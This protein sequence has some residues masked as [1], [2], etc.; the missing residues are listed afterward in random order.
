M[1]RTLAVL[2]LIS[3]T[4]NIHAQQQDGKAAARAIFASAAQSHRAVVDAEW[5]IHAELEAEEEF[6]IPEGQLGEG[7]IRR[8]WRVES[9]AD[10]GAG[11]ALSGVT[12]Y[13]EQ[14]DGV[15]LIDKPRVSWTIRECKNCID[16]SARQSIHP[17]IENASIFSMN[18]DD[19]SKSDDPIESMDKLDGGTISAGLL[20]DG[21][22]HLP[23]DFP[24]TVTTK[25][26]EN[27]AV[28]RIKFKQLN[29]L[30]IYR[31]EG[32]ADAW[33]FVSHSTI[34]DPPD[35]ANSWTTRIEWT[36]IPSSDGKAV[37][38]PT[39]WESAGRVLG[40]DHKKS[41]R[42]LNAAIDLESQPKTYYQKLFEEKQA[43][44]K[45]LSEEEY[46]LIESELRKERAL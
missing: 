26:A 19:D 15:E 18:M 30:M 4:A 41:R 35:V 39:Y 43:L 13:S 32:G 16:I 34:S 8:R 11:I 45:S 25:T 1:F 9:V 29:Y 42:I 21:F 3:A 37:L 14:T 27:S 2:V 28:V 40:Q 12:R 46:R 6:T 22:S 33:R 44:V 38:I 20:Q 17:I 5:T 36:P 31:F 23:D 7:H 10:R 24:V